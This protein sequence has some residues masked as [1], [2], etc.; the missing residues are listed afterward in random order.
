MDWEDFAVQLFNP[1]NKFWPAGAPTS[2][3][4]MRVL[5]RDLLTAMLNMQSGLEGD[6]KVAVLIELMEHRRAN[7]RYTFEEAQDA[8]ASFERRVQQVS[9]S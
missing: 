6:S 4:F 5:G 2:L 8:V 7:A 1:A 3:E 9:G